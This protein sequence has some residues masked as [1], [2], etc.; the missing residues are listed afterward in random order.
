MKKIDLIDRL[1][2]DLLS[3]S[4]YLLNNV[5]VGLTFELAPSNFYLM[6]IASNKSQLT[7]SDTN[8]YMDLVK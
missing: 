8:L 5:S 4:K 3:Q 2:L 7:I 1:N 6:R